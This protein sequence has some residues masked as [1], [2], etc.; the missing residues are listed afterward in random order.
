MT[1]LET[2][3]GPVVSANQDEDRAFVCIRR[4][5][6]NLVGVWLTRAELDR[7]ITMLHAVRGKLP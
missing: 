6:G 4:G 5:D 1:E 7:L 3:D 2:A